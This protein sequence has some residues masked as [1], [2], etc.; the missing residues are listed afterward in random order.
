MADRP[1]KGTPEY[2]PWIA[3]IEIATFPPTSIRPGSEPK[4]AAIRIEALRTALEACGIDWR[5]AKAT[6]DEQRRDARARATAARQE[7]N[8]IRNAAAEGRAS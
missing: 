1:A 5:K 8:R 2:D 7:A 3:A 6:D 4:V